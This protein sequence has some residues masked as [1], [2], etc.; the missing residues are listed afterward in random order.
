MDCVRSIAFTIPGS[1]GK[2]GIDLLVVENPD[3]TLT[4]TVDVA[5][6]QGRPADLRGLFFDLA[7]ETK[8]AGL[9]FSGGDD[10]ITGFQ[11]QA[12]NVIDL[13]QGANMHGAVKGGFDVGLKF[14]LS[15]IGQGRGNVLDPVT[16]TLDN[17]AHNLTLDDIANVVFGAR[18]TSGGQKLTFIAPAAPDARDDTFSIFEDGQSGLTS[19]SH[20]PQGVLF[21]V[22]ANDTDADGN[23]LTI[24]HVEGNQ[25]GTVQI[26]DGDDADLLAGD[27]V[28]YTPNADYDGTDSFTYCITDN[29]GG[30]DFANVNVAIAAVADTPLL[31]YEIAAGDAVNEIRLTVTA[32]QT[33][34]DSSEF[35]DRIVLSGLP[36]GVIVSEALVNPGDQP[37]QLVHQFILTLPAD[38]DVNFDLGITAVSQETSNGDEEVASVSVPIVLE[39]TVTNVDAA[40]QAIDQS[41]WDT[42]NQF[43][44]TDDRFLGIDTSW[45]TSGGGFVYGATDGHLK[46][47]FQ[48]TLNFEGG[49][50]DA[51]VPYDITVETS[52]NKTTDVLFLTADATLGAA[53]FATEGPEGS[54]ALDFI[55][56]FLMNASAGLAFGELG[57]WDIFS[58]TIGPWDVDQNILELDSSDLS[59]QVPLPAGFSLSFEWPNV[60]TTSGVS[61]T[62]VVTSSGA[63]NNF[64]ELGLDVDDLVFTLL[65]IPNP[66]SIGFDIEVADGSIDLLDLDLA[67]GLNFLQNFALTI[68]SLTGVIT[69]EDGSSQAFDFNSDITLTNASSCDANHDGQIGYILELAPNAT[70]DN[71]TDLGFNFGY[72]F[73]VLKL[74]G[75]YDIGVDSGSLDLGPVFSAN[76]N[77]PLGSVDVYDQTF[78]L[79]FGE[80]D[81]LFAA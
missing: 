37:D 21:Q 40:F 39:H 35:V 49:E 50:I 41:M 44:F 62:N 33:D 75:S 63:S 59:A 78:A 42:G 79:N 22:L 74:S 7:D 31:S 11:A 64:L 61:A 25:H 8:L 56:S 14:A 13:G 17:T 73:D 27:A 29:H 18:T 54:Y 77:F 10:L 1:S 65:G 43:T 12:N 16:F 72:Q 81:F 76:D 80:Q 5:D 58:T 32:T 36:A 6:D 45:N 24:T 66:L 4:F 19:P 52:Y 26:V 48:S 30:T 71:D 20:V 9:H 38:T 23:T 68:G 46:A 67:A 2:A 57:S 70:L 47:G 55:F 15:G 34:L 60:D 51:S 28:L 53:S 3:G 69:F